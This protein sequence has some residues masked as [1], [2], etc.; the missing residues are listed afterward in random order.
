MA[1]T[2]RATRTTTLP[3]KTAY[4]LGNLILALILDSIVK[5]LIFY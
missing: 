2:T 3:P 5:S 1:G 4:V